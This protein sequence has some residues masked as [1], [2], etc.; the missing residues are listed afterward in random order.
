MLSKGDRLCHLLLVGL[1]LISGI[2]WLLVDN[3]LHLVFLDGSGRVLH[4][5][6][7]AHAGC[8]LVSAETVEVDACN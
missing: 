7:H 3:G 4:R 1:L 5:R 8:V 6:G 2:N